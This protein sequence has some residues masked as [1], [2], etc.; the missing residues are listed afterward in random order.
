MDM[1]FIKLWLMIIPIVIG[2]QCGYVPGPLASTNHTVIINLDCNNS[3]PSPRYIPLQLRDNATH[4]AVQLFH[5]HTVPVGLFTN[6]SDN[7]TSVTFA[8]EDAVN[9]PEGTFE[10]LGQIAELRLLGFTKLKNLSRSVLEPLRNI[11]TLILDG[12]GSV[13]IK[14]SDLGSVIEKLSGSPIR[15][16]VLNKIKDRLFFQQIMRIDNFRISNASVKELIITDAPFSYEG[17]IRQAFPDLVCF[18]AG[19]TTVQTA[20]TLPAFWDLVLLSDLLKVF[21]IYRP[22]GIPAVQPGNAPYDPIP[23]KHLVPSIIQ[24]GANLY[25]ELFNYVRSRSAVEREDC[26]LGF[27]LSLGANLSKI[28]VN[29]FAVPIKFEKGF[30]FE[31]N[32]NVTYLDLSGSY[33][34]GRPLFI[35]FKKVRY[36]SIE[37]TG[38]KEF[39]NTF[40]EYF[41][42]LKVFKSGKN[43]IGDFIKITDGHFFGLCQAL[44]EIHLDECN[45]TKV[46]TT[47]FLRSFNIQHIDFSNNYLRTVGL[48][49]QNCTK[50]N[51]LNFS[52]NSIETISRKGITQLS[53]PALQK[54]RGSYLVVDL[55]YNKLHCLCNST[56]FIKWLQRS[57]RDSNIKFQNFDS[58][59]C[60]YPNGSIVPVS[61]VVISELEQQCSVIQELVNGSGCP[62][63][64]ELRRR[65]GQVWVYLDGFFCRNNDGDLVAMKNQ[66]LPSCFNP[67]LRASFIAPVVIGGVLGITVLITVGLLIYY[68]NSRRVKQVRE[69][70]EMNPFHFVHTALEYVMI[71]NHAEEQASFQYDMIIFVQDEDRSS[72]HGRF[73]GALQSTRKCIT[74]DDFLPGVAEVDAM[75]ESIRVCQWIV[76]VLT[77]NFLSDPVC[78]DFISRVQFS[79]PHALIPIVWEQSLAV[80]DVAVAELLRVGEPLY[81]PGDQA[82]HENKLNFWSVL[83][84]RT[85]PL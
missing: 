23:L 37:N 48:D 73:I 62:C 17:S 33:V 66:P 74:R 11:Q 69:C 1:R 53:Q 80:T 14:L 28:T 36:F 63:D 15:R 16:L 45:I 55:S 8:S 39:P 72:I 25:P 26:E 41:P 20:V 46:P 77:S 54:P 85:V 10:G 61:A 52:R 58:Y 83:L 68:R 32:N 43:D 30:C 67:Y 70:L 65:I 60:L 76:P 71:H 78:V 7:L 31:E 24:S 27:A 6:V 18:C 59:T 9:L 49:L 42:S 3:T 21:V 4:V 12:F 47:I 50:L 29:G 44:E 81:W 57:P 38:V 82:A 35:G 34:S 2:E 13:N 84:E 79:R 64:E 40:L 56:H 5:C 51:I 22:K 75:V 19:G